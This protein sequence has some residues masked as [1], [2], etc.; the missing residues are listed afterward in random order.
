MKTPLIFA[1]RGASA[2]APENTMAAF[3]LAHELGAD[4][5]ELDVMLSADGKMV[6][7]HDHAVDRTTNG[8]GKVRQMTWEQLKT[9]DAGIK[10][11]ARF[12]GEPLPLLEQVFEELGG[13]ILINVELKNDATPG[14]Q[15]TETV[16]DLIR[17][18]GL[19]DAIILSSFVARNLLK[20]ERLE[21][22]VERGLLTRPH[23]LGAPFRGW[24]GKHYH[25][26]AL[27]PFFKDVTPRLVR[28]L[29]A[30]NKKV[31]VWT[32]DKPADLLRMKELGVDSVI[33]NDPAHARKV[34]E[35]T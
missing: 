13:Q 4:G 35:S 30:E 1:H 6:V 21:P 7:I 19:Q 23:L 10:F 27:H 8:Q 2:L 26:N 18:T 31:N 20:A 22:S 5:I 33:C 11:D 16:I 12:N 14:D 9:L 24:L 34:L 32:V 3:R 28:R 15:L 25:Y 17:R 29:H